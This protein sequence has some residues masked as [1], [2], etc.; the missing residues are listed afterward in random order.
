MVPYIASTAVW[1]VHGAA[2]ARVRV[3]SCRLN[4]N[5]INIQLDL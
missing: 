3:S 4:V 2:Q 1:S 5:A